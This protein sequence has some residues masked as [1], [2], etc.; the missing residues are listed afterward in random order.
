MSLIQAFILGIVQGLTEFLPVSSSW[1]LVVVEKVF[2]IEEGLITFNVAV[3]FATLIAVVYVLRKDVWQMIRHPFSKLTKFVIVA[4]IPTVIIGYLVEDK[5]KALMI[6]AN[7]IGFLF[8][9]SGILFIVSEWI[10]KKYSKKKDLDDIGYRH[11]IVLGLAQGAAVFPAISRS[12][13]TLAT[14]LM[15]GMKREL[16]IKISFLM[17]I[18]I[19]L[20]SAILEAKD[21]IF[22]DEGVVVTVEWLPIIVGMISAAIAGYF[23][24]KFMLKIFEKYS[25]KAFAIYVIALGGLIVFD[26]FVT[27]IFF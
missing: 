6:S 10:G 26:Q 4:T 17:S 13:T 3:H 16:T 25:L 20:G 14:G 23:A 18:P 11:A 5:V 24:V 15:Q 22:P 7:C 9:F 1:H 8:I 19:I 2:G 27:K 21:I 12:G